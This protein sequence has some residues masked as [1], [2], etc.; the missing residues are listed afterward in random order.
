[1]LAR[2]DVLGGE[3]GDGGEHGGGHQEQKADKLF[4]NAHRRRI[5]QPSAVGNNGN[6]EKGDLNKAVLKGH[7]NPH[8]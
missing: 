5:V 7:R 8:R 1:M 3:G 6:Q 2:T 4:H